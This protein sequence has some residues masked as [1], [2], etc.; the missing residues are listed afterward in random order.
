M[1]KV[2]P[3]YLSHRQSGFDLMLFEAYL[4]YLSRKSMQPKQ[5][6]CCCRGRKVR[7][8]DHLTARSRVS[9]EER[10]VL[11]Y[12]MLSAC[13]LDQY[14]YYT[15]WQWIQNWTKLSLQHSLV[16]Q[17]IRRLVLY[18][19]LC[20]MPVSPT[21]EGCRCQSC[22]QADTPSSLTAQCIVLKTFYR[23]YFC[24]RGFVSMSVS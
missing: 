16:P 11:I 1:A 5:L 3:L 10:G 14:W 8:P 7:Q 9:C 20:P 6:Q 17:C 21:F 2:I 23:F 18:C 4:I 19:S 24:Q 12:A 13:G 22:Y 15:F